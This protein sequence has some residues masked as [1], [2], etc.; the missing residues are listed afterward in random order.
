MIVAPKRVAALEKQIAELEKKLET[1]V[2]I[3]LA[4]GA[5]Y[6]DFRGATGEVHIHIDGKAEVVAPEPVPVR[7]EAPFAPG[8]VEGLPIEGAEIEHKKADDG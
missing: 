5:S 4:E 3:N 6:Q 1:P 8:T 2:T 7:I